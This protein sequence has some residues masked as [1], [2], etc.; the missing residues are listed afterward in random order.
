MLARRLLEQQ[1]ERQAAWSVQGC[2]CLCREV[3][4]GAWF[5]H[6]PTLAPNLLILLC[7]TA[8]AVSQIEGPAAPRHANHVAG[9]GVPGGA[10]YSVPA[11]LLAEL[12]SQL[13]EKD[14][15]IAELRRQ[16]QDLQLAAARQ[17]SSEGHKAAM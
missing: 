9:V 10:T 1:G 3:E 7:S 16:V 6:P 14:R 15:T 5:F 8:N 2:V 13:E 17:T 4:L 12:Q 11:D